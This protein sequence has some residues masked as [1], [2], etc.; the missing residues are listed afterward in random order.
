[1]RLSRIHLAGFK[2]FV[3]P[4]TL[5]LP[6]QRVGIV[7]PNGCGKSNTIDAV[8]WVMGESSARH[9]RGDDSADV[10][11]S[12]SASR[13]PVGQASV[14]LVFDNS[15]AQRGGGAVGAWAQ[16]SE[17]SIRR[18]ISREG[19][20][21]YWLNGHRARRRDVLDLFLGTG[22]GPRSYAIIEQGM[23]T[24][25]IEAKP[26]D[27]RNTIEEAAGISR[28][29]ERR[30]ETEQRIRH[31]RENLA[32]LDDVREELRRQMARLERQAE[33][34]RRYRELAAE[35]RRLEAEVAALELLG[36][37]F[38]Y[39]ARAEQAKRS[40]Q[41]VDQARAQADTAAARF[42]VE[43]A[44][45][46][47]LEDAYG[48]TQARYYEAQNESGRQRARLAAAE[49]DA[50]R[51]LEAIASLES[52]TEMLM[53]DAETAEARRHDAETELNLRVDELTGLREALE[54]AETSERECANEEQR[55]REAE[56]RL[57]ESIAEPRTQAQVE[58][59]TMDR[60]DQAL[61]RLAARESRLAERLAQ[62]TPD[63]NDSDGEQSVTESLAAARHRLPELEA[64]LRDAETARQNARTALDHAREDAHR[65]ARERDALKGRIAGQKAALEH[66]A[67]VDERA[68]IEWL[69]RNG[70]SAELATGETQTATLGTALEVEPGWE[71][72]AETVLEGWLRAVVLTAP[73]E[74][75]PPPGAR[76]LVRPETVE[77]QKS[78]PE[79]TSKAELGDEE[80]TV[81]RPWAADSLENGDP[82]WLWQRLNLALDVLPGLARVATAEDEG[83]AERWLLDTRVESVVLRDGRWLGRSWWQVPGGDPG[84][85]FLERARAL[86]ELEGRL[87]E[88]SVAVTAADKCVEQQAQTLVH[89]ENAARIALGVVDEHRRALV[90]L[91]QQWRRLDERRRAREAERT[92]VL[93]EREEIARE[94]AQ[95]REARDSA[96][97]R[98][99][100]AL[101]RFEG[102][103]REMVE[104]DAALQAAIAAHRDAT[105][106]LRGLRAKQAEVDA[107][108]RLAEQA[109]SNAERE[110]TRL[111]RE[112]AEAAGERDRL[113]QL[114]EARLAELPELRASS[115]AMMEQ[116]RAVDAGLQQSREALKACDTLLEKLRAEQGEAVRALDALR[117]RAESVRLAAATSEAALRDARERLR[118]RVTAWL[119]GAGRLQN[120]APALD[121]ASASDQAQPAGVDVAA[122]AGT[123]ASTSGA[124]LKDDSEG[125]DTGA[126][127]DARPGLAEGS[128]ERA[129]GRSLSKVESAGS[130]VVPPWQGIT[131]PPVQ[132]GAASLDETRDV[133]HHV[134]REVDHDSSSRTKAA[135]KA[136][137]RKAAERETFADWVERLSAIEWFL[138]AED[139]PWRRYLAPRALAHVL[140]SSWRPAD[141]IDG[142]DDTDA[143]CHPDRAV[144]NGGPSAANESPLHSG[145]SHA[146]GEGSSQRRAATAT[147][148][149][150]ELS[151]RAE[152]WLT[153]L[154]PAEEFVA[155]PSYAATVNDAVTAALS[156]RVSRLDVIE[157]RIRALGPIHLAA[158]DELDEVAGRAKY[159]DDQ[160]D[161]LTAA[162][163]TLEA[164]MD[165]ID[166]E[167]KTLFRS[168]FD[169]INAELGAK[170]Q[171]LFGGG[172][173]RLELTGDDLLT[174]GIA[175][176]ARPPGKRLSTIHLMS[177]GEKTLTTLALVFA[178]F[179][180]NPAPF[181][182]LDEV[183]AP[184]D[185]ANVGRFCRMLE[186]M[187]ADTQF[188]FIS[189]NK[190]TMQVAEQLIGVTMAEPGVSRLVAV[191]LERALDLATTVV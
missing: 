80:S 174:T 11:F 127:P 119:E 64:A 82:V 124:N 154:G 35:Q 102:L 158:I 132:G 131:S 36:H 130:S 114:R 43:R 145:D 4:T 67:A 120:D 179:S 89:A 183:D 28:Y 167:T 59:A 118:R 72:A 56:R 107:A 122:S 90:G 32:R 24:R 178:I 189:H 97:I 166:R 41:A 93:A 79:P 136:H 161:D 186:A 66:N 83:D 125:R 148:D 164:A 103:E 177:G 184:L 45:R 39:H 115:Q 96:E 33:A 70:S 173:A 14:E 99:N 71:A 94:M 108:R 61:E 60:L 6:G 162:L 100:T 81:L 147:D 48:Q 18:E 9:L 53:R 8:R 54:R 65:L 78:K 25:L 2:S 126:W 165:K 160:S 169:A 185:E 38:D 155:Q 157:R 176:V 168:T 34:A 44:R 110:R 172:E 123:Q 142:M 171:L 188:L 23:I 75:S 27:L 91:E 151:A 141:A 29:K 74:Q 135:A 42:D 149:Q 175:I 191:D 26:E 129:P 51:T 12:G 139:Q 105:A 153:A 58:R 106:Q 138:A 190:A 10:I 163:A 31:T 101:A 111:A 170:F 49:R 15:E 117:E 47:E 46:R 73:P 109:Q 57:R 86:R 112:L 133:D 69:R 1:M 68:L 52:R 87:A 85:G 182:M 50:A 55:A 134:E 104:I 62:L 19:P 140:A 150:D 3:D 113:Q 7:G 159:F 63:G 144:R 76:C 152:A 16:F 137:G 37:A 88:L 92:R 146:A 121:L 20:S 128:V 156:P 116:E 17:I 22:L 84:R 5:E 77:A 21:K 98:R 181:C 180:L 30:R 187:S 143:V 40:G 95:D 13:K